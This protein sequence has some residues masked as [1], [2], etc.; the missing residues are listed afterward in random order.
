MSRAEVLE[1]DLC[2]LEC[3]HL[4]G[5]IILCS[6]RR[7]LGTASVHISALIYIEDEFIIFVADLEISVLAIAVV[8]QLNPDTIVSDEEDVAAGV[9][10]VRVYRAIISRTCVGI[11][12]QDEVCA[13][14]FAPGVDAGGVSGVG[15]AIHAV[16]FGT[17]CI[18]SSAV[19]ASGICINAMASVASSMCANSPAAEA[20]GICA[21]SRASIARSIYTNSATA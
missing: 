2:A 3:V 4:A 8:V 6:H 21:N 5:P 11:A 19:V 9:F 14:V 1:P 15:S 7:I 10:G 17:A 13:A 18:N 12:A 20:R 16:E